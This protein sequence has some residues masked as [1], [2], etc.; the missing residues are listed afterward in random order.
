MNP[1]EHI[2]IHRPSRHEKR[3][4]AR[5][6]LVLILSTV[7][8]LL[9]LVYGFV[10]KKEADLA[11]DQAVE[12]QRTAI[13]AKIE[14]DYQRMQAIAAQKEADA[15]RQAAMQAVADCAKNKK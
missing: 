3:T 8:S 6:Q 5:T 4:K 10:Q 9:F 12:A 11:R 7:I 1:E 2:D 13:Q 14:S 15:Q